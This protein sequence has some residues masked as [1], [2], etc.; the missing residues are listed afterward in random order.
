MG[1][2]D[3]RSTGRY[4]QTPQYWDLEA[5]YTLQSDYR[6]LQQQNA[7]LRARLDE[8]DPLF[9]R[10]VNTLENAHSLAVTLQDEMRLAQ[11]QRDLLY[12]GTQVVSRLHDYERQDGAT[13]CTKCRYEFPCE[14]RIVADRILRGVTELGPVKTSP[15]FSGEGSS[16]PWSISR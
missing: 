13:W 1:W 4:G 12:E 9:N 15:L 3:D 11:T 14:T 2:R 5:A 8:I 16:P 6:Y 10:S 7:Q